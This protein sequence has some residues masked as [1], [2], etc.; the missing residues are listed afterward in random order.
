MRQNAI[1]ESLRLE[2]NKVIKKKMQTTKTDKWEPF[3]L[4]LIYFV[5]FKH[6]LKL[7]PVTP[8]L[9]S[10]A[11]SA[12]FSPPDCTPGCPANITVVTESTEGFAR[13]FWNQMSMACN[14]TISSS[15]RSGSFFLVGVETVSL[16]FLDGRELVSSCSFD[17]TVVR[18][19]RASLVSLFSMPL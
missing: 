5:D 14:Y 4:A 15:H 3:R 12:R 11:F 16:E 1:D 19:N 8:S 13:V 7:G 6:T 2:S 18:G 10:L 9:L 17:V